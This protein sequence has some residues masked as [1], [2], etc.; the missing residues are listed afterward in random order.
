MQDQD[1]SSEVDYMVLINF[2]TLGRIF[3]REQMRSFGRR[4]HAAGILVSPELFAGYL[5][6]TCVVASLFLA[7][8]LM[9]LP[10]SNNYFTNLINSA[11]LSLKLPSVALKLIAIITM[12]LLSFVAVLFTLYIFLSAILILRTDARKNAVEVILPDFLTLISANVRAGMTLDQAIWY[13]AKPEFGILSIEV[14]NV[15]KGAFSGESLNSALDKL[16]ERFDSRV[17]DRT[18][19]LIK[20]ASYTGGEVAKILE[21]TASDAR[22]TAMLKKDI[23]ASLLIYEIFVI[24]SAALGAPFLFA[25]VNKLLATLEKSFEFLLPSAGVQSV[26]FIKPSTPLITA[27]DFFYFSLATIFITTL[28][29]SFMV[30]VVQTGSKNQGL[31][32]FPFMLI[33]A[34]AVYFI[35]SSLL[36]SFFSTML[37]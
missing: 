33:G 16:N 9:F 4:I 11:L 24:F 20:Q 22:E 14:R 25:V 19:S 2:E 18:I 21:M 35:V 36:E 34:Y 31:K 28:I 13:S 5:V 17:L 1:I 8:V 30:G 12:L 29:S 7:L 27:V 10:A 37:I 23:A 26:S 6:A 15:I 3:S 32:Y